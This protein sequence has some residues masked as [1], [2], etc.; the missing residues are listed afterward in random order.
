MHAIGWPAESQDLRLCRGGAAAGLKNPSPGASSGMRRT[1]G[2]GH[3][4][5]GGSPRIWCSDARRRPRSHTRSSRGMLRRICATRR[6]V[7]LGGRPSSARPGPHTTYDE[8]KMALKNTATMTVIIGQKSVLHCSVW[9][10]TSAQC[11]TNSASFSVVL[12]DA[13]Q[14][15][16][17]S[18][19]VMNPTLG[20]SPI[21][22]HQS[23]TSWAKK[24]S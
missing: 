15:Q 18:C 6:R 16:T 19:L 23:C 10:S 20:I 13:A 5:G 4:G 9:C 14:F 8:S 12:L 11:N 7:S 1:D 3:G 21:S 22:L 24:N 2:R 17:S